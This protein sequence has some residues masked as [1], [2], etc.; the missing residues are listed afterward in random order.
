[1]DAAGAALPRVASHYMYGALGGMG[2]L[3]VPLN[4]TRELAEA[5]C[6]DWLM[7][8]PWAITENK[9]VNAPMCAYFDF[10]WSFAT[11]TQVQDAESEWPLVVQMMVR[12]MARF[13]PAAPPGADM[14]YGIVLASGLRVQASDGTD[15][16]HPSFTAAVAAAAPLSSAAAPAAGGGGDDPD[17][18]AEDD[19]GDAP[20]LTSTFTPPG[21]LKSSSAR[22]HAGIHVVFPNLRVD[23][24]QNLFLAAAVAARLDT[25]GLKC[26]SAPSW[27]H[28]IDKAVYHESRGLRWAWQ[29]KDKACTACF[30]TSTGK[31]TACNGLKRVPDRC[32]SM[33]TARARIRGTD[34]VDTVLLAA[35]TSPTADLMVEA[36]IRGCDLEPV[37][38]PG[39]E[40]YVGHPPLPI[41]TKKKDG[42]IQTFPDFCSSKTRAGSDEAELARDDGRFPLLTACIKKFAPAYHDITVGRVTYKV[43]AA[44]VYRVQVH[45]FGSKYCGNKGGHH[46][47]STIWFSVSPKGIVQRC[48]CPKVFNGV[49]CK[50]FYSASAPLPPEV[51]D[52]FF[53]TCGGGGGGAGSAGGGSTGPGGASTSALTSFASSAEL[54]A[55][56]LAAQACAP[57]VFETASVLGVWGAA[58]VGTGSTPRET[59]CRLIQTRRDLWMQVKR[60]REERKRGTAGGPGVGAAGAGAGAGAPTGS[61]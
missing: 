8:I 30:K 13:W 11:E 23:V 55:A 40:L 9:P 1:M 50:K 47:K 54:S 32:A 7:G 19:G 61:G 5:L 48:Y 37:K 25:A 51:Q 21:L 27:D 52:M 57:S 3:A 36:S 43:G 53:V 18:S 59:D 42:S 14:F 12:E 2:K 4:F 38:T 6:R 17:G 60:Q 39:W 26:G 49:A 35:I 56:Q 46:G 33:Y 45:G 29:V 34:L 20:G 10:D 15:P 31:C 44:P 41:I 24:E 22:F 58:P 16:E 28:V